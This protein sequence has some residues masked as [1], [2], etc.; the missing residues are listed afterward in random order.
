MMSNK[1]LRKLL[2]LCAFIAPISVTIL[3]TAQAAPDQPRYRIEVIV[4]KSL[5]GLDNQEY[6]PS[7]QNKTALQDNDSATAGIEASGKIVK[8]SDRPES[9]SEL[10]ETQQK[11]MDS[12]EYL[13]LDYRTWYQYADARSQSP[14]T[15]YDSRYENIGHLKGQ[16]QFYMSRFLHLNVD[17]GIVPEYFDTAR[18]MIDTG[19]EGVDLRPV[20]SIQQSKRIKSG[21][22]YYFDHPEFGVIVHIK[23]LSS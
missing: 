9:N 20:Y 16:I 15:Y 1:K 3:K 2:F 19:A 23:S 5:A 18:T 13:I 8:H 6:W 22:Y 21:N 11:L 10:S 4:F 17:L 12:G 14:V 7:L